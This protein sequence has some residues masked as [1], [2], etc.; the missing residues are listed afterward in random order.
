MKNNI[1]ERVLKDSSS[2][3]V[4]QIKKESLAIKDSNNVKDISQARKMV[5][6]YIINFV[7]FNHLK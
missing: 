5:S 3:L 2:A 1:Q 7:D 4:E 6:N